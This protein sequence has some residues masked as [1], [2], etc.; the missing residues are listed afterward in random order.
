MQS[1]ARKKLPCSEANLKIIQ[2]GLWQV[3]NAP[4]GTGRAINVTGA[5]A[6]GKTGSA[7]NALGRT[8]HAWFTGYIVTEKPE[9]VVTVFLENAGGGGAMAAPITNKI[10]NYYI[11]NLERIKKPAP[12]PAKFRSS[13]EQPVTEDEPVEPTD[14]DE[15]QPTDTPP[16]DLAPPEQAPRPEE[17]E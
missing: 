9:I 10:M 13:G 11:G 2:E 14:S 6:Y 15:K 17:T 3:C 16:V 4:G 8:T 7:E 1:I 12:L 5:T